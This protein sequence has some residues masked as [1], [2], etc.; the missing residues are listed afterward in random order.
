MAELPTSTERIL[1][2]IFI[3]VVGGVIVW[4]LTSQYGP[5]MTVGHHQP[6]VSDSHNQPPLNPPNE[7]ASS[8][9]SPP[10]KG[11]SP[12]SLTAEEHYTRGRALAGANNLGPAIT[13]LEE[14]LRLKPDFT[15]AQEDLRSILKLKEEINASMAEHRAL[16]EQKPDDPRLYLQLAADFENEGDLDSAVVQCRRA[17]DLSRSRSLASRT[18]ESRMDLSYGHQDLA[19]ILGKKGDLDEGISEI[20]ESIRLAGKSWDTAFRHEILAQLLEA[21]GDLPG[22]LGEYSTAYKMYPGDDIASHVKDL[23]AKLAR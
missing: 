2:G 5:R 19:R 22:A 21:K 6:E 10:S 12:Q 8:V 3:T 20:R 7:H 11:A 23:R 15:Q 14:A 18:W 16:I 17:I 13:E 9:H 1:E 4:W